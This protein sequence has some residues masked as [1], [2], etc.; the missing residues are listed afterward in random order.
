MRPPVPLSQVTALKGEKTSVHQQLPGRQS[1]RISEDV[2]F[3][4]RISADVGSRVRTS[5]FLRVVGLRAIISERIVDL[6]LILRGLWLSYKSP[7]T[8]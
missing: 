5:E 8:Q 2:W 3:R 4:V 7:S 1:F 6:P